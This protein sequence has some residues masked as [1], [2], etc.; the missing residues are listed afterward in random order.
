MIKKEGIPARIIVLATVIG[1]LLGAMAGLL[2]APQSG[3]I[4][5]ENIR[6]TYGTAV[7]N[8]KNIPSRVD[9]KVASIAEKVVSKAKELP[10]QIISEAGRIAKEAE[11][12]LNR[13]VEK[14][15]AY[16]HKLRESAGLALQDG[17]N[18]FLEKKGLF[19]VN[20]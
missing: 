19:T 3:E 9:E 13:T 18:K 10:E 12:T 5:R 2:V 16:V 11:I 14:G 4:T 7:K 15:S 1:C 20:K 6:E 17:K 8:I